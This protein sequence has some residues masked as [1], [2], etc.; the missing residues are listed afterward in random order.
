MNNGNKNEE[1]L[2]AVND[3]KTKEAD[4]KDNKTDKTKNDLIHDPNHNFY[5][6]RLS[7]FS[8]ISSIE[9][10]FNTLEMFC[11]EFTGLKSL[12]PRTKEIASH[13]SVV[14]NN[15]LKEYNKLIKEYKKVY[16]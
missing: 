7:K 3:Q 1:L 9:T 4:K 15:A 5:K 11:R 10:K 12:Q 6:Y 14:L 8:Q 2:K 16:E 13:K